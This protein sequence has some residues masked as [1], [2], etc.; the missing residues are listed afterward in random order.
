M[1]CWY[2]FK[3]HPGLFQCVKM[4]LYKEAWE[5]HMYSLVCYGTTQKYKASLKSENTVIVWTQRT[6]PCFQWNAVLCFKVSSFGLDAGRLFFSFDAWSILGIVNTAV[7]RCLCCRMLWCLGT[8][9]PPCP[10]SLLSTHSL[11]LWCLE[12]FLLCFRQPAG[13]AA[14]LWR[15]TLSFAGFPV[16]ACWSLSVTHPVWDQ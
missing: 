5:I 8:S 4:D 14:Q 16:N 12:S 11:G 13:L 9:V 1:A 15:G 10:A 6:P 3:E 2:V 7:G